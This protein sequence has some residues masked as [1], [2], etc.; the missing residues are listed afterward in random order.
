MPPLGMGV[1]ALAT[2]EIKA[3]AEPKAMRQLRIL[4][5]SLMVFCIGDFVKKVDGLC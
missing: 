1:W 2:D 5:W 4:V 3:A